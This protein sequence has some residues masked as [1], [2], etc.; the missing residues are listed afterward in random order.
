M[1]NWSQGEIPGLG[2]GTEKFI[3][4]LT[5]FES[6]G[7]PAAFEK[8]NGGFYGRYQ[9]GPDELAEVGTINAA[10]LKELYPPNMRR[11]AWRAKALRDNR[12]W[13]YPGGAE[14]Y[15]KDPARQDADY[16]KRIGAFRKRAIAEGVMKET[17]PPEKWAGFYHATQLG[18]G[19]AKAALRGQRGDKD[20]NGVTPSDHFARGVAA[21]NGK[22]PVKTPPPAVTQVAQ[23]APFKMRGDSG[24]I[25]DMPGMA[26]APDV[27]PPMRRQ[28]EMA[29]VEKPP[30]LDVSSLGVPYS[31]E[32]NTDTFLAGVRS[33]MKGM[34]EDIWSK[35]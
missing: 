1:S 21:L 27:A 35:V 5:R 12:I 6:G 10:K 26:D 33:R 4:A 9:F 11:G 16:L 28:R 15:G 18:Y 23:A 3:A 19:G 25:P 20:G 30:E 17:D 32:N 13:A 8:K 31:D 2:A 29:A 34:A 7:N 24:L 22:L 14:A